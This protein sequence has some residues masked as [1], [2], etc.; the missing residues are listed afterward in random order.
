MTDLLEIFTPFP[1]SPHYC[2]D[3]VVFRWMTPFARPFVSRKDRVVMMSSCR[4]P[5]SDGVTFLQL[6]RRTFLANQPTVRTAA[7]CNGN[8]GRQTAG[9]PLIEES[10]TE[11][12]TVAAAGAAAA[13]EAIASDNQPKRDQLAMSNV[14]S[15]ARR[16]AVQQQ[17]VAR[18][19]IKNTAKNTTI[20]YESKQVEFIEYCEKIYLGMA[21]ATV[22]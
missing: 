3:E 14:V 16:N 13:A 17:L 2:R 11:T 7:H 4:Y 5:S 20:A 9:E 12:T 1:D 18:A 15:V 10:A 8:Q 6:D 21:P 19:L 22:V